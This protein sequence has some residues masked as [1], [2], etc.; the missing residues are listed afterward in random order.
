MR[1]QLILHVLFLFFQ[2]A[3]GAL[4]NRGTEFMVAF[5][6][7]KIL[8][9][10]DIQ[11]EIFVTTAKNKLVH[12]TITGAPN[13]KLHQTFTVTRGQVHRA[14]FDTSYRLVQTELARKAILIQADDEIVVYGVNREVFSDDAYL[15]LPTDVLGNEYYTLSYSP[16]YYYCLFAV[17]GIQDN[18]HVSIR[19]PNTPNLNITLKGHTYQ[20]NQWINVTLDRFSTLEIHAIPDLT[21]S[22]VVSD[23]PVGV[24]SGNKKA[25]VGLTG[26]SRDHLVEMLLPI[27]SWGKNYA[28]VPIPERTVGDIFRF[29]SSEDNTHVN[30]TGVINGKPFHDTLTIPKA[31]QYAQ[32]QYDSALYS[33]IVSD[34]PISLFQFSKTQK[35]GDL[36]DPAMIIVPPIEQ[37]AADYTFTTPKYSKGDYTNYFMFIVDSTQKAGLRLDNKPLPQNQHYVS[38]PGTNLVAGYIK[39]S[40]GTH[41]VS[42][43]N[44]TSVIGA[45]LFGKANLES[46]GF[47]VGLL[48]TP[49]NTG[50]QTQKMQYGDEIDNDCDGEIDEEECDGKDNDGDGRIDEDCTCCGELLKNPAIGR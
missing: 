17:I 26:S 43:T 37:Y 42:H 33:H 46:Y 14:A 5:M 4:D 11:P 36:A 16:S 24:L 34:K 8:E 45:I 29:L 23:K 18:T 20:R 40:V 41:S 2:L 13:S 27:S 49:V 7:N 1:I 39:I 32:K 47:P 35:T 3:L 25:V 10:N 30:I 21:G 9:N 31:G 15:A 44:P 48:L 28:T 38:I 12:V 22:Y 50:C 19:L 6:D